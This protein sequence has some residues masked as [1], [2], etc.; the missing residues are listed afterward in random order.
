MVLALL[1]LTGCG[2]DGVSYYEVRGTIHQNGVPLDKIQV[3]FYPVFKG[4]P[5]VAITNKYGQYVLQG[6]RGILGAAVGKHRVVLR[7]TTLWGTTI[8]RFNEDK[9]LSLD[10]DGKRIPNR[11]PKSKEKSKDPGDIQ[12]TPLEWEVHSGKNTLDIDLARDPFAPTTINR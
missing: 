12:S 2:G 10:K 8:G 6:P 3:D 9:D 5:S 11:I 7:D 4:Q 1:G